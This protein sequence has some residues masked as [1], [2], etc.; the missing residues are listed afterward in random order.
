MKNVILFSLLIYSSVLL[1]QQPHSLGECIRRAWAQNPGYRNAAIRVKEAQADYVASVGA[2]L[3]RVGM[4]AEAGRRFGRSIDPITNAYTSATFDEG[5]VGL[6][7]T[8]SLFEG[9][10]RLNRVRFQ[11]LNRSRNRWAQQQEQNELAYRVTDA[12]YRILLEQKMLQLAEEQNRLGERYLRQA[13]AFEELGLKSPS[14]LQE[15][16]ARREGD[17]YRYESRRNSLRLALL[18][19]KQLM[20]CPP[21]DTLV[22]EHSIDYEQ[23]PLLLAPQA[24]QLYAQSLAVMPSVHMMELQLKAARKQY[25]IAGGAFS[26]TVF[27]RFSMASNYMDGFSSR[28]LND[29]LGRYLGVGISFPLLSGLE[30]ITTLRK[31]KLN[32]HRLHNEDEV[33]RQQLYTEV[34]QVALSLA[35]GQTEHRQALLQLQAETRVLKE[36]ERKWEEGIISVF[37]LMEARSRFISAKAELVRIRLQVDMMLRLEAYYKTGSFEADCETETTPNS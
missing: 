25:A 9:F 13:E 1:A 17:L 36:S 31:Q 24:D 21:A 11:R 30:R 23:L 3:P 27:A 33:Q 14:D 28:Q 15:V 37:Q 8:L 18:E 7:V 6:D 19:L 22:I 26:P 2:F 29:N 4:T 35:A 16:R 10:G 5:A 12:Y 34:Q 20:N 32:L